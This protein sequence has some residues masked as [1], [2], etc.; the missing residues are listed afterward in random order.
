MKILVVGASADISVELNKTLIASGATVGLHYN[1]N[2]IEVSG[3]NVK[4][5]QKNLNSKQ[6][7][8]ELLAEFHVWSHG[9]DALIQ[10]S[11]NI[12]HPTHW[13]VLGQDGWDS[14]LRDNLIM[15]FYLAQSAEQYMGRGGRIILTS[16]ASACHGGGTDS[17][18]YGVAKAGIECVVK[19][20]AKDC[21]NR[22]I[23]VNAIAPGFFKSKFH[24]EKMRRSP[25]QLEHRAGLVPLKRAGTTK[26]FSDAVMYLL[27]AT[28]MTGEVL[29]VSGGDWL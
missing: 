22:N 20:L 4:T 9:I 2:P 5:F 27:S 28:Y 1:T 23:L 11:G 25:E 16:T 21:A 15:P 24:T 12:K 13:R 3:E 6:A 18:A 17:L 29:T 26:E 7:C 10:L 8:S 19:R 14:D